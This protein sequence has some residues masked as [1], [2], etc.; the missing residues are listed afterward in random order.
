MVTSSFAHVAH[1]GPFDAK[2]LDASSQARVY[3]AGNVVYGCAMTGSGSF[4]LGQRSGCVGAGHV[5]PVR[6]AGQLAAYGLTRCG[7]DT[8]F[9]QVTVRR[10]TDGKRLRR[11]AA[12]TSPGVESFQS[13]AS[14]VL[15]ADGAVAW[16]GTGHSIIAHGTPRVE[17]YAADHGAPARQVDSGLSIRPGSLTL[18][19]RQ[20]GWK[21]HGVVRHATL[22]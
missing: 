14:L 18:H 2:T 16:I 22:V 17:V 3:A 13:V 10:L 8:G 7:V 5:G 20:L 6:V 15:R 12:T 1:C 9:A 4:R 11:F 19:G 21:D